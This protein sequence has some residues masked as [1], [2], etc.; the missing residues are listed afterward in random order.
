MA[1]HHPLG[2]G[3][4]PHEQAAVRLELGRPPVHEGTHQIP[5]RAGDFRV[6]AVATWWLRGRPG[7][8]VTSYGRR[9]RPAFAAY[10]SIGTA[11]A[12]R[13]AKAARAAA[14]TAA[15]SRQSSSPTDGL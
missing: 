12:M 9:G 5:A 13:A 14:R 11:A 6:S 1:R 7:G 3:S 4:Q 8:G 15:G 2:L 10:S